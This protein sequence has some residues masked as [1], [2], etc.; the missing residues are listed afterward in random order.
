M[1]E[2]F[3]RLL[4]SVHGERKRFEC[5]VS[6]PLDRKELSEKLDHLRSIE[7]D[8]DRTSF[9]SKRLL[10][11]SLLNPETSKRVGIDDF[12]DI[13]EYHVIISN[14]ERLSDLELELFET[15]VKLND[16]VAST[17]T[18]LKLSAPS[19]GYGLKEY[20][21]DAHKLVEKAYLGLK[22][23]QNA[24]EVLRSKNVVDKETNIEYR[25]G[26]ISLENR[27]KLLD[28]IRGKPF[29][30]WLILMEQRIWGNVRHWNKHRRSWKKY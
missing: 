9:Y 14:F 2:H 28:F 18:T 1:H 5:M 7:T 25:P 11:Y 10:T 13:L 3:N 12:R 16:Q 26:F 30:E 21:E 29:S 24:L 22:N 23:E 6:L 17:K 19:P 8:T 27:K 4:D 15:L 20:Y